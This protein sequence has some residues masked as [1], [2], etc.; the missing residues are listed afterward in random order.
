MKRIIAFFISAMMFMSLVCMVPISAEPKTEGLVNSAPSQ[1]DIMN[2]I[3]EHKNE[4]SEDYSVS[5]DKAFTK[6][7]DASS[8]GVDDM[9]TLSEATQKKALARLN[10]MR[11]IAG[12]DPVSLNATHEKNAQ[13]IAQYH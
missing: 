2:Y 13:A 6:R 11:Y 7:E 5:Y 3:Q 1:Q 8:Y 12:E 10:L 9:G 4:I